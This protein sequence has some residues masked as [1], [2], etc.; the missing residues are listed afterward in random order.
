MRTNFIKAESKNSAMGKAINIALN[1]RA[2][3]IHV[4]VDKKSPIERHI[5]EFHT[6]SKIYIMEEGSMSARDFGLFGCNSA[7]YQEGLYQESTCDFEQ[8]L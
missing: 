4:L 8:T 3:I 1:C 6:G 2:E 5:T 7:I